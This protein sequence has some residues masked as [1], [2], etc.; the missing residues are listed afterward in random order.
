M[1]SAL[2]QNKIASFTEYIDNYDDPNGEQTQI[3]HENTDMAL[4]PNLV[5]N[6]GFTY[7]PIENL[8][9][10][11]MT[12]YVGE[13]FLTTHLIKTTTIERLMLFLYQPFIKLYT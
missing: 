10:T 4:S 2:S 11:W 6:I 8:S 7:E 5:G 9:F 12:K 3:V 1:D 13:Q